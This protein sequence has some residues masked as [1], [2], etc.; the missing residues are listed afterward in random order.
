MAIEWLTS[1][2]ACTTLEPQKLTIPA[3]ETREVR[4]VLDLSPQSPKAKQLPVREFATEFGA[5]LRTKGREF[6]ESWKVRGSVRAV[7][8]PDDIVVDFGRTSELA[9]PLAVNRMKVATL[10]PLSGFEVQSDSQQ[11]AARIVKDGE[12]PTHQVVEIEPK[13]QLP[14]GD[15]SCKIALRP[16]PTTGQQQPTFYLYVRGLIVQDVQA[17][18]PQAAFGPKVVGEDVRETITLFSLTERPVSI[19]SVAAVGNGLSVEKSGPE[20]G[21]IPT[22]VVTQRV[23]KVGEQQGRVV[24][25][26]RK[27]DGSNEELVIG[28][29]YRGL[30]R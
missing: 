24:V 18:P 13:A 6:R 4:V 11:I 5:T 14:R 30:T 27:Q 25:M 12:N 2:C 9:Q 29:S 19:A 16:R 15:F 8:R 7:V 3:G 28:V 17:S 22:L 21:P 1:S 26:V 23:V 20:S 10:V